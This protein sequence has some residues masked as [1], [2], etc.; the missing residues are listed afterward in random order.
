MN[1]DNLKIEIK[2]IYGPV[3]GLENYIS[4][5]WR[6][7]LEIGFLTIGVIGLTFYFSIYLLEYLNTG[8]DF[9]HLESLILGF[10]GLAFTIWIKFFLLESF[11]FSYYF[12]EVPS[13]NFY[14]D[15][16]LASTV[17]NLDPKDIGYSFFKTKYGKVFLM[18]SGISS[19]ELDDF[20]GQRTSILTDKNFNSKYTEKGM[21]LGDFIL[22]ITDSDKQ[23]ADFLFKFG[24]Q[25]KE[26]LG[27]SEWIVELYMSKAQE[28]RWWS[29]ENLGRVPSIGRNWSYGQIYTIKKYER[30]L[31]L[32]S[33]KNYRVHSSYGVKE[34]AELEAVLLKSRDANVILVGDDEAG[35]LQIISDLAQMIFEGSSMDKLDHK[36]IILIDDDKLVASNGTKSD[37]ETEFIKL[38]EEAVTAG[39]VILVIEDLPSLVSSCA[40]IG[41]DFASIIE[42]YLTSSG[43]QV[44]ALSGTDGFHSVVERNSIL[45]QHF[46][47]ILIKEIDETNTIKVLQNEVLNLERSG[48]FFTYTSLETIVESSERYFPFGV[49]PDKAVDLLLE[50]APKLLSEGKS[51]VF[52]ND[53]L[54]LVEIKT[55]IPVTGVSSLEKD[56]LLNLEEILHKRIVGQDEAVKTISNAV[57]RARSGITN[58]NRPLGSF[59]FLGPTGVGKTETTKALAQVFFG[60]NV[61]ILRLDMSEYS[62]A[63][64]VS[65]LIGSFEG[66]QTGV[67][68]TM[69]KEHPYGVLL[70][71]EFEKT[72]KEVMN[73]FL[74]VLDE[75]FFSDM[76]G[77]K[78]MARNLI[79]IATSNA[80]SDLIWEAMQ[81][82]EDMTKA[83]DSIIDGIIKSR[84]FKPELMN[85]FDGVVLFH[86]LE[87]VHLRKIAELQLQKL[88][89]RLSGQGIN[90]VINENLLN[91]VVSFGSDPKFGARPMNRAIQEKVE[92]IVA[93]KIIAGS[94]PKGSTVELAKEELI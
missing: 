58:P 68:S 43:L 21:T 9:L 3:L 44:I 83:K 87:D 80:G 41:V 51:V 64:S 16:E 6:R 72:T 70:L 8:V 13:S 69:L 35:K 92:E 79:I 91:Y 22:A 11:Y 32:G 25:K 88:H 61:N 39:N 37:F 76:N 38:L 14:I 34:L 46:E 49:M 7:K 77:K 63:D 50:I 26:I 89:E 40:S 94:I 36:R 81:N 55:G 75:G 28:K 82:K 84:I 5:I 57:R 74:Q 59:L 12:K 4:H 45:S 17:F 1:L 93:R 62:G 10:T 27:I 24:I 54:E 19:K 67:L 42:S 18:R 60:D 66:K 15:F 47:S 65:K 2:K 33:T 71:D 90:L 52:K 56:K 53:V 73:L 86:P 29:K 23:F 31:V 85:R 48:L 20:L 30:P 78:I